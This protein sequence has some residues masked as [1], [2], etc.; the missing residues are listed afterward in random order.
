MDLNENN[1]NYDN[2]EAFPKKMKQQNNNFTENNHDEENIEIFKDENNGNKHLPSIN[3]TNEVNSAINTNNENDK[4]KK[5]ATALSSAITQTDQLTNL[6]MNYRNR[7][8]KN[9][10]NLA[11]K[12]LNSIFLL[13]C[14]PFF[15]LLCNLKLF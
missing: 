10:M 11:I 9:E 13:V 2:I 12:R 14:V 15:L 4:L 7:N 3:F 8:E 5:I 6:K 1:N